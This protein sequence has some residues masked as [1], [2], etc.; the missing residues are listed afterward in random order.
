MIL[1]ANAE[2]GMNTIDENGSQGNILEVFCSHVNPRRLPLKFWKMFLPRSSN[3]ERELKLLTKV[4][5]LITV[6]VHAIF[7]RIR[8]VNLV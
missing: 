2:Y 3:D 7:V 4:Y 1:S 5:V 6:S 8:R